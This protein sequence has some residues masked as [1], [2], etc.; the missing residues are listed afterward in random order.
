MQ[1]TEILCIAPHHTEAHYARTNDLALRWTAALLHWTTLHHIFVDFYLYHLFV[2]NLPK[3]TFDIVILFSNPN[4]GG[5][6]KNLLTIPI[7]NKTIR[8]A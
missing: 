2:S 8:F 1:H 4:V 5:L 7:Y 3:N 6:K